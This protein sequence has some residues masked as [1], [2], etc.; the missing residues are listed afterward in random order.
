MPAYSFFKTTGRHRGD[1][2]PSSGSGNVH[3]LKNY[4]LSCHGDQHF[5]LAS[6][7]SKTLI[8]PLTFEQKKWFPFVPCSELAC[9]LGITK[10]I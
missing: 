10:V 9:T 5:G 6:H 1:G 8:L 2:V 4:H 3:V 7:V